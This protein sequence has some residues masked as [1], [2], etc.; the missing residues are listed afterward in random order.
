MMLIALLGLTALPL[1]VATTRPAAAPTPIP[2]YIP[3]P[4]LSDEFDGTAL[5]PAK[6]DTRDPGWPGRQPGLF[7]PANVVVGG[8][9]LQLWARAARRNA[10]WPAGYDNYT[11]SAVHSIATVRLGF[12]EI[13]WRSGS[14]GISSSWWFHANNGTTWTEIDVFET[15]GTTN[16]ARNGLNAS[17]LP[18]H[19]HV[20]AL[21]GVAP[22]A[23]PA[24][25]GCAESHAGVAPCSKGADFALPGGAAFSAAFHTASLN[26]TDAGVVVALDGAVVTTIQSPCLVEEIGMDFDRETMPGWMALPDPASLP[27]VPFTVDYVRA[28]QRA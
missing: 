5:D 3:I 13:R 1:S 22:A 20:F 14:S 25:C 27:D 10:S 7:D 24:M 26:W 12:F 16:P 9:T 15:T 4:A 18:S 17:T 2:G 6:W 23:L 28:W 8:G 21:P 19:V 11:T